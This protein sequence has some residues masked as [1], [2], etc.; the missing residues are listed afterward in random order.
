MGIDETPSISLLELRSRCRR[1]KKEHGLDLIVIDYLQLM[2]P[3][4]T[5]KYESREREISEI[6]GG[7]KALAKELCVPVIALA[8]LNR[9]VEGRPDKVPKLSD[10]RESGSMEQDADMIMFIYRDEYYNPES[11]QAG[12][13]LIRIGKNR[14]GALEDIYLAFAPNFLK[15]TNLQQS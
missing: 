11:E 12:K 5:K 4:G 15:F 3:S 10:L 6:S 9:G 13:A 1:F 7:L 2:G 14:H 8:Q